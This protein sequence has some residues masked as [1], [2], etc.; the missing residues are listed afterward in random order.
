MVPAHVAPTFVVDVSEVADRRLAAIQAYRSQL[1]DP[2]SREPG[3]YLS[4]PDFLRD[5]ESLHAYYGTLIGKPLAEAFYVR[6][7]LGIP[8]PVAF[9]RQQPYVRLR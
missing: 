8:D 4:R 2:E 9:F 3:T 6:G 7:V 5:V 1:F